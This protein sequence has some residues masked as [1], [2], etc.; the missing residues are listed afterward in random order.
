MAPRRCGCASDSWGGA[1]E[2]GPGIDVGGT[3][4]PTNPY[5]ITAIPVTNPNL[6]VQDENTLVRSGV[7]TIDFQGDGVVA[8]PGAAGEVIVTIVK[9]PASTGIGSITPT[10]QVFASGGTWT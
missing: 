10:C 2:R 3:G 7:D 9:P 8:T 6:S 5:T 4:S 1:I